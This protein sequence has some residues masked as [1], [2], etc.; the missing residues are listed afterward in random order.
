MGSL[1]A[2]WDD[3]RTFALSLA[4][5]RSQSRRHL[6]HSPAQPRILWGRKHTVIMHCEKEAFR[7]SASPTP[8]FR[9]KISIDKQKQLFY[10]SVHKIQCLIEIKREKEYA[11][12]NKYP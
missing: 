9:C 5:L 8:T 6:P 3:Y 4:T 7:P 12:I 1:C 2:T 11:I 10:T